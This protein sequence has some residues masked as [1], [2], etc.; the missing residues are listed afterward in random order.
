M[1]DSSGCIS[2]DRNYGN[3]PPNINPDMENIIFVSYDMVQD[4]REPDG[5]F[6]KPDARISDGNFC[7]PDGD[8]CEPDALEEG[9]DGVC[10]GMLLQKMAAHTYPATQGMQERGM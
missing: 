3:L 2:A 1:K 7:M 8:Y 5:D 6:C 10:S 4:A 9:E